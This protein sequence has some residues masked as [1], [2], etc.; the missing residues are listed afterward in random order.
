[1]GMSSS[2]AQLLT[3][4]SR[5]HDVEYKTQR[6][7]DEKLALATQKD[8]VYQNYVDKLDAKKIQVGF[9]NSDGTKNYVDATF[10]NLCSYDEARY[11]KQYTLLDSNS[12][13]VYVEQKVADMYQEFKGGDK[14]SF[15][16]AMLGLEKSYSFDD[17]TYNS[18]NYM[19]QG[20]LIGF[21]TQQDDDFNYIVDYLLMTDMEEEAFNEYI[22]VNTND[23]LKSLY[24]ELK[25]IAEDDTK[26]LTEKDEALSIFRDELYFKLSSKIYNKMILDKNSPQENPKTLKNF[27]QDFPQNEFNY[28]IRLFEEIEACGGC[29][30]LDAKYQSGQ[31]GN[32][33]LNS[34]VNSGRVL[35]E[36]YNTDKKQW[37]STSVATNTANNNLQEVSDE[38]DLKKAEMD[39]QYE[40]NIINTKETRLD[41]TVSK[42]ETE[43]SAITK[44]MET[45]K[46]V[47]K[48]NVE[49]TFGIFS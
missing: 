33:W 48:D 8:E 21:D 45:L 10:A 9:L 5:M 22:E 16:W 30:S 31:D 42:L 34:M 43:R 37:V 35:I 15:A 14:Y 47:A 3:L 49:R 28:Y 36:M 29:I 7:L 1:M 2:Q 46:T 18:P 4:T 26:S 27:P 39:Y 32:E 24:E 40:L 44:E 23:T 41:K 12:G 25:K 11:N 17:T 19:G 13:K 6:C 38:T 20:V